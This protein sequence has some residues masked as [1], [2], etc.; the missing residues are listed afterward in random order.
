MGAKEV[1]L[2]G[3]PDEN[4]G[5]KIILSIVPAEIMIKKESF[6]RIWL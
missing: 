4:K 3:I 2:V 1:V 5:S 6:L